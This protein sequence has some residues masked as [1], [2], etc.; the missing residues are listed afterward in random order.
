M[1]NGLSWWLRQYRICLQFRRRGFDSWVWKIPWRREWATHSS[2]HAW[3]I[4]WTEEPGRLQSTW[5]QITG[6]GWGTNTFI[7]I[8]MVNAVT[9]GVCGYAFWQSSCPASSG[10]TRERTRIQG[11]ERKCVWVM[12]GLA[13]GRGNLDNSLKERRMVIAKAEVEQ[14]TNIFQGQKSWFYWQMQSWERWR[15]SNRTRRA[16]PNVDYS[17]TTM[18]WTP[19]KLT[20][21]AVIVSIHCG[22]YRGRQDGCMDRWILDSWMDDKGR[23]GWLLRW[24]VICHM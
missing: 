15:V 6:H 19:W 20:R 5:S 16:D 2:I 23:K 1:V 10:L 17:Q 7:F 8:L 4:P 12:R 24:M 3:R 9:T 18:H 11:R 14:K 13:Q 22:R 21:E